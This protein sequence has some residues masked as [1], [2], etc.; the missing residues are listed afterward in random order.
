VRDGET[1]ESTVVNGEEGRRA[2][3]AGNSDERSSLN[4]NNQLITEYTLE[5]N[6]KNINKKGKLTVILFFVVFIQI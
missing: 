2:P 3:W 5:E 6:H 1:R 4:S